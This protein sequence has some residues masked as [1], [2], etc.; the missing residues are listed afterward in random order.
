MLLS[1]IAN[2]L[3]SRLQ[4]SNSSKNELCPACY[5]LLPVVSGRFELFNPRPSINVSII[6]LFS[7]SLGNQEVD[8]EGEEE[9]WDERW[10][11]IPN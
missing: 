8:E 10:W 6:D 5:T 2:A 11:R 9:A 1:Q 4:V 3:F 7:F